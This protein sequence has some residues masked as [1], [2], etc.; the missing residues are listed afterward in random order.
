MS[1][2]LLSVAAPLSSAG[3][4]VQILNL[5]L[6]GGQDV[7]L[8][9]A[10]LEFKPDVVGLTSTTPLIKSCYRIAS[11]V[12]T[13]KKD[14][15]IIAGG[16][17]PTALP[18]NV[19]QESEIDCVVL[20]EGDFILKRI[21]SEGLSS[22][23]PN[24]YF[25]QNGSII[26]S[27]KQGE[28]VKDVDSLPFP[29]YHLLDINA[30]YQPRISSRK[31]PLGYLETSRGCYGKCIFCNKNIHGHMMR[32]KSP[33]KV[34]DDIQSMLKLGFKE[35]Q[36]VDD[37]F[38]ADMGRAYKICE[39]ILKRNLKFSWYPRGGLRVDRVSTDLLKMMKRAGCYRVPF[40][41]ESG[42]QQVLDRIGKRITC[43]QAEDAVRAAKEADLEVECYFMIGLPGE[44]EEDI[45]RSLDF[46]VKLDP[47]YVKFA[48]TVPL[49]GTPMFEEM[50]SRK[51]IKTK[52]WEKYNFSVSPKELYNHDTLDW[53]VIDKFYNLSHRKF[54]F[55]PSY[56]SRM[57]Y[58]T[59]LNGT[60]FSH[61]YAFFR[62][63]W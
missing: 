9:K 6:Q 17:H 34:V 42:S 18:E 37:L 30:Y 52:D 31:R 1:L 55:R 14:T 22:S 12:K 60:F 24:I 43:G 21:V 41:I 16:P 56:L 59:L 3:Y 61:I 4:N 38:T 26:K 63:E 58:K 20:G 25:R 53:E 62:T 57:V 8:R 50:D 39:E 5:N 15:L 36:I 32:M 19:L 29:A 33:L 28:V 44:T 11:L 27:D 46:A 2:G 13:L 47:D 7:T 49:P 54:Y 23:I 40:G 10:I 45:R 51:Q 35:I 48:I